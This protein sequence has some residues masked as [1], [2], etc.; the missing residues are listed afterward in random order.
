MQIAIF[1]FRS[2]FLGFDLLFQSIEA[3]S[4][5]AKLNGRG[6]EAARG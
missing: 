4:M 6:H 3:Y 1:D 5:K 2:V